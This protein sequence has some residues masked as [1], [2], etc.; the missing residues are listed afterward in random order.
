MAALLQ[1]MLLKQFASYAAV[2][3]CHGFTG[4]KQNDFLHTPAN[5]QRYGNDYGHIHKLLG[6]SFMAEADSVE[7]TVDVF[8]Q[9]KRNGMGRD[10][11]GKHSNIGVKNL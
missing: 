11:I 3:D 1:G 9:P 10:Q 8:Q 5:G 7:K 2:V 6:R 4:Y